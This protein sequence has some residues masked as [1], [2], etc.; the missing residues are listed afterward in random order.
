MNKI[1]NIK[2]FS[3]H[4]NSINEHIEQVILTEGSTEAAKEMEYVLVDAA[5]GPKHKKVYKH[6]RPYAIKALN[7]KFAKSDT[8]SIDLGKLIL[9]NARLPRNSGT[10]RMSKSA[11]VSSNWRGGNKTPKTDIIIASNKISLKKGSS[12]IMSGGGAESLSTFEAATNAMGVAFTGELA[13]LA[14][15]VQTG[16]NNLLPS[17]VGTQKGGL[18]TQKYGG[19]VYQ[20][21]RKK[22]GV[23]ATIKKSKGGKGYG[24]IDK[25]KTL[26]EADKLNRDMTG[27]FAQLFT[28]SPQ[29]KKE[30]VFE[31]MTGKV[32]FGGNEGTAT[33]FL[34]VDF[35]GS[36]SYH[37]VTQSSDDYV[38]TILSQVNPSVKFK[39]TAVK[40]KID[41]IDTKTGHYRFWSTVGLMYNAAAKTQN[42][43]YDMMNSGELEYLSEGFFDFI[44]KAWNKFKSFV[45]NL[46]EKVKNWIKKSVNNMM[47]YFQLQPNVRFR[48]QVRW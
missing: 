41:G 31:A 3:E 37:K 17:Y 4:G 13:T 7:G 39:S 38:G 29:F 26:R 18:D 28:G 6:V 32:K 34:V 10:N 35:D 2:S 8:P 27:K 33:H 42:E 5:G 30:F 12:Q 21:T 24:E 46:I 43:V 40:K 20:D 23:I 25:D 11:P 45:K 14:D 19:T 48:N 9:K 16:I 36:A 44:S 1:P 15:Q 47:E 22:K